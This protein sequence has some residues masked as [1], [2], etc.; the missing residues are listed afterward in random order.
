MHHTALFIGAHPDDIEIGAGASAAKLIAL[1][2]T[3]YFCI[4]TE[5]Q[6]QEKARRRKMEA[7][8]AA[9]SIGVAEEHVF[10][11]GLPDGELQPRREHI[12][13]IRKAIASR[14]RGGI[15]LLFSHSAADTHIDHQNA[16]RMAPLLVKRRPILCYPIVNH[17]KPSDFEPRLFIDV[18]DHQ[19]S[20]RRAL[21]EYRS[22]IGLRRILFGQI[23]RLAREYGRE[24]GRTFVEPFE[25]EYVWPTKGELLD[26]AGSLSCRKAEPSRARGSARWIAALAIV[27]IIVAAAHYLIDL[28]ELLHVHQGAIVL[29]E[30]ES[31]SHIN[32]RIDGFAA[33]RYDDLKIVVYV[34][35]DRWY[36]HPWDSVEAGKGYA[37]VAGDG[38][39]RIA[40]VWRGHQARRLAILLVERSTMVPATVRSLGNA[41]RRLLSTVDHL[42]A[43]ILEPPRGI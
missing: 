11:V 23:E 7:L 13:A 38:S 34:L 26:L 19:E 16:N 12:D 33:E 35:T 5:E 31:D 39:W 6:D 40:T 28:R 42:N 32:G 41:E 29:E 36:I 8:S 15:D 18:S 43:L 22:Q 37:L 25:L 14:I 1:G 30:F 2:W 21:E 10:F 17:L 20:K 9:A 24:C 4:L 27:A 3:V